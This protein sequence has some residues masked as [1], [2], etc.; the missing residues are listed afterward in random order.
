MLSKCMHVED[1]MANLTI[2]N[3]ENSVV[4]RL[5]DKAAKNGRSLEAEL[6]EV[7]KQAANRKTREELLAAADRIAAMTPKGIKQTDSAELIRED[8]DR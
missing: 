8:P 4:E 2:R 3:I 5:K 1:D 7:L 6:R